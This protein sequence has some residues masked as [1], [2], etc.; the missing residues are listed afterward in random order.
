MS[1][2]PRRNLTVAIMGPD[3]A[4]KTTLVTLLP[5]R[6]GI[7][8]VVVY[9]GVN[10]ESR[11]HGLP[12]MRWAQRR[13]R[14]RGEGPPEDIQRTARRRTLRALHAI[15]TTV[16]VIHLVLDQLYRERTARRTAPSG[17][18]IVFDRYPIDSRV[19]ADLDPH[20]RQA[21]LHSVLAGRIFRPPDLLL[22]LDA[23]GEVL[24]ARKGEHSPERLERLRRAYA[25]LAAD[26]PASVFLD[27]TQPSPVV[28]DSAVSAIR[29]HYALSQ[30]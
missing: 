25:A 5:K 12:T 19:D 1:H 6:L 13:L 20:S 30:R 8:C 26:M 17:A 7:P 24:F 9:M 2:T 27:A 4:G 29:D 28:L 14:P 3:G 23:P 18:L 10:P 22:I 11:T 15:R 21:G 16:T